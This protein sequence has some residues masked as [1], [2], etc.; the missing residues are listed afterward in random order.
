[1]VPE[2]KR[3]HND[4]EWL[5]KNMHKLQEKYAGRFIAVVNEHISVGNTATAAYGKSKKQFPENEPL[6]D[7]VPSKECLLL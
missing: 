2:E 7:I 4:F 1:M 3:I 6:M 5:R